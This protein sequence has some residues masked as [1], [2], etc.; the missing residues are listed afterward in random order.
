MQDLLLAYRVFVRIAELKSF[1]LAADSL[2]LSNTYVSTLVRQLELQLG[3]RLL[4]R[5]TRKVQ[6][7]SDGQLFYPRCV[8]LIAEFDEL[9]QLFLPRAGELHGKLRIDLP[10]RIANQLVLPAIPAVLAAH[11]QLQLEVSCTDRKVDLV[12]EGFDLV[13]RIGSV[14]TEGLVAKPIGQ[15]ALALAASPAYLARY[16]IPARLADLAGHQQVHYVPYFAAQDP[17]PAYLQDGEC[18]YFPLPGAVTVNHTDSYKTACQQGL[19]I[20]QAPRMGL[21]A[22]FADGSLVEV[23]PDLPQPAMPVWLLYPHRRHLTPRLQ[24]AI[25]WLSDLIQPFLQQA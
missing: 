17:G 9:N 22:Y 12:A 7:T 21:A 25:H 14:D 23:L 24:W 18:R 5:T 8:E 15:A 6:L 11:P 16:G 20:I 1:H 19:G 13:L 10:T 2:G 4:A 3:S